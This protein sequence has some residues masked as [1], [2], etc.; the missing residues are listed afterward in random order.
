M[1]NIESRTRSPA[2][3]ENRQSTNILKH[4]KETHCYIKV[5]VIQTYKTVKKG[6]KRKEREMEGRIDFHMTLSATT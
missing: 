4:E 2:E 1:F 3:S 6:T 5:S